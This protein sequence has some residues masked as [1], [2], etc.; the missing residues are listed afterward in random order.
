MGNDKALM[1][2]L[3]GAKAVMDKVEGDKPTT[4]S[5]DD[6]K[7]LPHEMNGEYLTEEQMAA[8]GNVSQ[9]L[10]KNMGIS[11]PTI[12]DGK[13]T[14]KNMSSSKMPDA[15]KQAMMESPIEQLSSPN[16]TFNLEDVST[17]VNEAPKQRRPKKTNQQKEIINTKKL[18]GLNET[19]VRGIV[20]EELFKFLTQYFTKGLTESVQRETIAE[21]KRQMKRK[22]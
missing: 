15:I 14:Y 19:Q 5:G 1:A 17:L 13:A 4:P 16:H 2:M 12:V 7:A 20:K 11:G 8:S 9:Q 21:V 3:Q 22:K 10:P 18:V 6:E